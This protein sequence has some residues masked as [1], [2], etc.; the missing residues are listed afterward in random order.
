MLERQTMEASQETLPAPRRHVEDVAL[1]AGGRYTAERVG[2]VLA[3]Q[4]DNSSIGLVLGA[5]LFP[6]IGL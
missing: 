1:E 3:E 6:L 4:G 5:C 2:V